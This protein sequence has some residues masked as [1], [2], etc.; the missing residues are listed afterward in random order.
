MIEIDLTSIN[1]D[2]YPNIGQMDVFSETMAMSLMSK[3][4]DP[5]I[6]TF[7]VAIVKVRKEWVY[8]QV[9]KYLVSTLSSFKFLT[10]IA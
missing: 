4:T 3:N 9:A 5:E 2:K 1:A 10:T 6:K 7:L 8:K